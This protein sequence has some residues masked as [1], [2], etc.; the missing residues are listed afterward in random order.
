MFVHD[1]IWDILSYQR[2]SR[3]GSHNQLH[4]SELHPRTRKP[5]QSRICDRNMAY[6]PVA[7]LITFPATFI[8]L[9]GSELLD[10][11]SKVHQPVISFPLLPLWWLSLEP[12]WTSSVHHLFFNASKISVVLARY[13]RDYWYHFTAWNVHIYTYCWE[14]YKDAYISKQE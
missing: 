4:W 12:T 1:L 6:S 7:W 10:R 2:N 13:R 3:D 14:W 11:I 8:N 5:S 9:F